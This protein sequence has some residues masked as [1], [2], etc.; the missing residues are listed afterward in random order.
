MKLNVKKIKP[1]RNPGMT[2]SKGSYHGLVY[3]NK[4]NR[5]VGKESDLEGDTTR[6]FDYDPEISWFCE[7]PETF[8]IKH[9]GK[10]ISYTPDFLVKRGDKF[11]FVEVKPDDKAADA[12]MKSRLASVGRY[13]VSA[14]HEFVLLTERQI[15][16][17]PRL[18]NVKT[19]SRMASK[20]CSAGNMIRVRDL[21]QDGS[22][23]SLGNLNVLLATN[24]N[25]PNAY[26]VI[27]DGYGTVDMSKPLNDN[28]L[29]SLRN[30]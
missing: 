24:D 22:Q 20:A 3:S 16:C 8:Q 2:T 18:N 19:I 17:Q 12:E 11:I 25:L 7:Q 6:L 9:E 14:G 26:S 1:V 15:R 28:T 27:R 29:V 23:I 13:F 21:I 10:M 4:L 5:Y 30:K